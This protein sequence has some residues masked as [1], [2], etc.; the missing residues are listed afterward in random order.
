MRQTRGVVLMHE[1]QHDE[2]RFVPFCIC[3]QRHFSKL[4]SRLE[5]ILTTRERDIALQILHGRSTTDIA[6]ILGL[7]VRTVRNRLQLLYHR[8]A[9]HSRRELE[10][11]IHDALCQSIEPAAQEGRVS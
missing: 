6:K 7:S 2:N 9:I 5:S 10:Y 3:R 8:F 4:P 1:E 11:L